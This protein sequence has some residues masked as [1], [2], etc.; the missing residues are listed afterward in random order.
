[1]SAAIGKILQAAR[2]DLELTLEDVSA[3]THIRVHYL[4]SIEAGDF[5]ALPSR[6]QLKGFL[7]SYASLLGLDENNLLNMLEHGELGNLPPEKLEPAPTKE[8]STSSGEDPVSRFVEVGQKLS[9]QRELLGLALDDV[10]RHTHLRVRYLK[11][12]EEGDLDG[13]PSPVQG[14][15]SIAA[16]RPGG[17]PGR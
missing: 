7:R 6:V 5:D 13:L 4:Q 2:K 15:G 12:L 1:M 10:E 14:R 11:A 17:S 3:A 16:P 9:E 8:S